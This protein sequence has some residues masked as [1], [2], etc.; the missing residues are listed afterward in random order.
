MSKQ[1]NLIA[2]DWLMPVLKDVFGELN[3]LLQRHDAP[4]AWQLIGQHLH[5][6]TG[7]LALANQ[8]A[9]SKLAKTLDK[10]TIAI[11]QETLSPQYFSQISHAVRLLQFDIE[12]VQAKQQIHTDWVNDRIAYFEQLLGIASTYE[13]IPPVTD[14]A[15]LFLS[16]LATPDIKHP[17]D[18]AQADEL[19]KVWRYNS[20]QLLQNATNDSKHL[21]A[22][23]KV[24]GYLSQAAINPAW[25]Q[26]WQLVAVWCNNLTINEQPAPTA[27]ASLLNSLSLLLTHDLTLTPDITVSRLAVDVLLALNALTHKSHD[28]KALLSS[29]DINSSDT[30]DNLFSQV[31]EK[32]EKIIYQVHEPLTILPLLE[33]VKNS[34]A[35]RGW[36]FYENQMA[37]IIDDVRLMTQD[38]F[39]ASSLSWQVERQLQ[40]FYSQLLSTVEILDSQI[41]LK[42]FAYASNP[43]NEAVRQTRVH[44]E[45]IKQSFNQYIQTRDLNKLTVNDELI[46]TIQVFGALGLTRPKELVEQI[47]LL[48]SRMHKNSVQVLSAEASDAI[49]DML[50]RF[51]LFLDYLSNQSVNEEFLDQT[52]TQLNRANLLLNRLIEMPLTAAEVIAPTKHFGSDTVI[53]DDGGEYIASDMKAPTQVLATASEA[54]IKQTAVTQTTGVQESQALAAARQALKADDYSM[55]ED[56]RDIF[57][58]EAQEVLA[59]LGEQIL[60]WEVDPRELVALKDIRRGFHTL[61]GSGR[62]VGAHQIG[63]MC[64]A[65]E[66]MLNRVLDGTLAVSDA[67]VG[68]IKDTHRKL[69]ILVEDF[70]QRRAPSIDPAVTVLQATNLLQQQPIN[71]GLPETNGLDSLVPVSANEAKDSDNMAQGIE[72]ASDTAPST[73]GDIHALPEVVAREY[74]QL[75]TVTDAVSDADIQEIYIEEANEVIETIAPLNQAWQAKPNDFDTLK[76]IR[77]GF[78][79]LKG[80]G[81]MVGANQLGELAWSI[82]N[83]LNRVLDHT[84]AV[85]EGVLR[86]VSDVI[87]AFGG[88]ITIFAQNRTDYPA[89]IQLWQA[90][91]NSYAKKHGDSFSYHQAL[92]AF[93]GQVAASPSASHTDVALSSGHATAQTQALQDVS[94]ISDI[95][96]EMD[97]AD[98]VF[99]EEADELLTDID[100]FITHHLGE[101]ATHVP[102]AI[103]RAFHT[104]RGGAALIGLNNVYHLSAAVEQALGDLLHNEMPLTASQLLTLQEAKDLLQ[105]YIDE[106]KIHHDVTV[107]EDNTDIVSD[108]IERLTDAN[109]E[110]YESTKLTVKDLIAL[111]IDDLLDA[112]QQAQARFAGESEQVSAYAEQLEQQASR[113]AQATE[114]L[115]YFIIPSTL[116]FAYKKLADYPQFAKNE[117]IYDGLMGLHNQLINMFDAIAA[118]LRVNINEEAIETLRKLLA[119]SQYQAEMDAIEYQ[120]IATDDELLQIFLDEVQTIQPD[121]QNYYNQWLNNLSNLEV[122]K[123]LAN[124]M[125]ILK[126]GAELIGVSSI[127]EMALRGEQVYDAIDKGILPSDTDTASLLQ[128]L[129]E[130]IASQLKQVRQFSRSFEATDFARQIDEV[131]AGTVQSRDLVFAV[132]LIVEANPEE[133]IEQK[134]PAKEGD[135]ALAKND[136]LYIE[137]IIN[138][139]EERRLETWKGQ[140]P[141]E[142]ILKVYLEEAKELIDSSSLHL[143]EFR[144]NNSDLAALQALQ[145]ELHT[146]KGGA[147]MVGAE[148]IA[149]LAH[150]METIYEELGSRRK[151]ATRMIGNLLAVCHDWLASA[152]YVLENKFNPQTPVALVAALQQFSRKPDSLKEIPNVNLTSQIEQIDIYRSSLGQDTLEVKQRDL[153]VMPLMTGNFESEQDQSSLN[154]ETLRI[155]ASTMERMINL[156]GESA[157]NRSRIEMGISSLSNN[158]EEMGATVQ[159]LADQ[160]RRMETELEIQILSQIGEEHE[161]EN[162]FDPLEMD[163]Y[164]ALNQLSKSL[165]ESASDL[166]DIKTT[167]LD[168]TRETENLLLQ[169]SRTQSDLQEGLMDSRTV[170]FSRITPRLQRVVRQTATELGKSVELRILNDEGEIDRNILERITSPLEHMLRNAVDHG[171]EK[172]QERIESGKSRTGLI[173]LEV[174]REGGEI[175]INLTDDGRGINVNAVREKAIEQGL[176]SA[177]DTSLKTLDIMQ[178]IF[179]AGLSTAKSVS[180][181]SGRGVGMDVVQS[182]VKQ[183]GGVVTVDS[184]P[185]RGSRF[186]MRLPLTVAVSD[187]LMVRAGDKYFAVPLVQIE[188]VMRVNIDAIANFY[189]TNA[190]TINIDGQAYRLRYLNQILYG[191]DPVDALAHQSSSVPVIIIR[192][193]LGQRMAL[194]VDMIAGSRI[195]VVVK[196]LGRQLSHIDG[197]SSATIMGDGSVM[198]ILDLVALMRNVS[199]IAK[200]EQQ[201]A[202]KSVKQAHKPVVLIVDDSVTVRKVTSRLLERHGYEAQVATDGIDALEKLQEM[203]PE[204]IVLDIEMPR[205]DGFEVANHIRHNSRLQHIPIVMITS[206]TGEK[207]RERAFDIGVNEYMGKP[208]QEQMLLDTLTRFTQQAKTD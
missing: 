11:Q 91:A 112:D 95:S 61:K 194:Q 162:D 122:V 74:E 47:R 13:P 146:I 68:F 175:V 33:S 207:H 54:P 92:S 37:Q 178:Y 29:L 204:V 187:A 156:S 110:S 199:N 64:W 14:N 165:S 76:E 39:M 118:G 164:S 117:A 69:P 52:Q 190:D 135:S 77:R 128:K 43:Q 101:P 34:L 195:E 28:T 105:T 124:Y 181:I 177:K 20:L 157:I 93:G 63:E 31:L 65:V 22:L 85:D 16:Q 166:L 2:L 134:Q 78:H 174:L 103:L 163:Q 45:H 35:N 57:I 97:V 26:F 168:K 161:L 79:T 7:A 137:E 169:L 130:T 70:Q 200:V 142:D 66:N 27:N 9:L 202:N 154:A 158:I 109:A 167:M 186:T 132:P 127:V 99:I 40:D 18:S 56:I 80:S 48:F 171:I 151:P 82:E 4:P 184:E 67:L 183:L 89:V 138:N 140:E 55:D 192:T 59:E 182:E 12:Q 113:L 155:S 51:E 179:N 5:Q 125:H 197:I 3:Q 1:R 98:D 88:L 38:T 141:D 86:L 191:S 62:M 206:R 44:I 188:R 46:A 129:H 160:L 17:W 143:Q 139:F 58:E 172:S 150:E 100:N 6:I 24:A 159:R 170:P 15:L 94:G 198:L 189:T 126:G 90:V 149:T 131:I 36:V 205:M 152:I 193:D 203:L 42:H 50:A 114:G 147:R 111:G 185:G 84:I 144:S 41:G 71:T 120:T 133:S 180:Q 72:V 108:L 107:V 196:P 106:H 145:R 176:I 60:V 115:S 49:A 32:L 81:R 153:S 173:T 23:S 123:E 87:E 102:D 8:P 25:R 121:V 53:Y 30:L 96:S 21:D 19:L 83:M 148:G 75:T 119:K 10:T 136:P 73:T 104:L 208:F 201:K 116:Q